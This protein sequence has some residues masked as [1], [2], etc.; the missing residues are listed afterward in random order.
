MAQT[1]KLQLVINAE[2]RTKTA[3]GSVNK[4][5]DTVKGKLERLQPAFRKMAVAG[6]V[7]FA[8]ISAG[9]FKATQ[10]ATNAQEIFNKFDVV[11]GDVSNQAERVAQ[12][13]RDNFG[14]AESSAK[15]LLS[16]TGDMLTGFGLSGEAA[17]DLAEKT[18][19]LAVDLASFTN[20]EGGAERA[21]IALT[22]ALLGERESVKEL[23]IAILEEDV[24]SKVKAM[25]AAGKFTDE[26]LRQKRALATLEIAIG[27]SK[28]AIGDFART[29][30]SL[31]NQK[32]VLNE[33][34][35]E[36]SETLG[37]IFM[38]VFQKITERLLPLI[39]NIAE[40]I[41]HN[42]KLTKGIVITA[43]AIVG[44]TAVIG[45][46]GLIIPGIITLW[47]KLN[48]AMIK[49]LGPLV[50]VA[51]ALSTIAYW[52]YEAFGGAKAKAEIESAQKLGD[53][54]KKMAEKLRDARK[55]IED[56]TG[57]IQVMGEK[58]KETADKIKGLEEEITKTIKDNSEKQQTY[59]E[60]LA[61]AYVDQ[62]EKVAEIIKQIK[63][64][65]AEYNQAA[66][67]ESSLA[68]LQ[69]LQ[70]TLTEEQTALEEHQ[71]M[72]IGL[73]P[74]IAEVR[75]KNELTE[76]ELRVETLMKMRTKEIEAFNQ[77][78]A[79]MQA[80]IDELKKSRSAMMDAEKEY[81]K[82]LAKE[83]DARAAKTEST[84][85]RIL[86]SMSER[87]SLSG[88]FNMGG[89]TTPAFILRQHGGPV[90]AGESYIVG[91][92][93]P[94]LF[95]PGQYGQISGVGGGSITVNITGNEFLGEEGV[96]ERI[97]NQIM[98]SLKDTVKL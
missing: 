29:E 6:T 62:E 78:V 15:D 36:L 66:D 64:K 73:F 76:F 90:T 49:S 79:L 35:K 24:K 48:I 25:E 34:T 27:Q 13:L 14:L 42:E 10:D 5:L 54:A 98:R 71:R 65:Q 97:G 77:K 41:E 95:T 50:A 51:V 86:N 91:E 39:E 58:T 4:S 17:L 7:A 22:K 23:G 94:E 2:N 1:H 83:E 28:N 89:A 21:S 82:D 20:L 31:A 8:A 32:R 60:E 43:A 75:R 68:E 69:I 93:G 67:K 33:R 16:A 11:F 56:I 88:G 37:T 40:W 44:I 47:G 84:T 59:R 30:K 46:L 57:A 85:Q 19:K 26:T 38:P 74:E 81:T 45:T 92:R 63:E 3:M 70:D 12:D 87:L 9:V 52:A 53:Q 18:N 72:K 61:E 80:E 96:A 55:P